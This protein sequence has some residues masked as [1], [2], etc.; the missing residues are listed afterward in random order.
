MAK[1]AKLSLSQLHEWTKRQSV[2]SVVIDNKNLEAFKSACSDAGIQIEIND[3]T[4]QETGF[5]ML[6]TTEQMLRFGK[7]FFRQSETKLNP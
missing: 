7:L 6:A 4:H 3:E 1:L 2:S 5:F